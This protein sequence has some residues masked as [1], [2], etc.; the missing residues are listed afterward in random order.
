MSIR[1]SAR[2]HSP[3]QVLSA[4]H[5]PKAVL[6]VGSDGLSLIG[7][8]PSAVNARIV[9]VRADTGAISEELASKFSDLK[10]VDA[11]VSSRGGVRPYFEASVQ[12]GS[13]L[14]HPDVL[15]GLWKNIKVQEEREVDTQAVSEIIQSHEIRPDWLFVGTLHAA[16]LMSEPYAWTDSVD[17]IALRT[18]VD[19]TDISAAPQYA[20]ASLDACM[21]RSGYRSVAALPARHPK[22]CTAIYVR[23]WKAAA[24][25]KLREQASRFEEQLEEKSVEIQNLSKEK[26]D[27]L[28]QL[29]DQSD[30]QSV[31]EDAALASKR[32]QLA[33][34]DLEDLRRRQKTMSE[35]YLE[36]AERLKE[37]EAHLAAAHEQLLSDLECQ[38]VVRSE[39]A[40]VE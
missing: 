27:L 31:R 30:L 19:P 22:L 2:I 4:L 1:V 23:D 18:V 12:Q 14:L 20:K 9:C 38:E 11:V 33:R 8:V 5:P 10:F 13:G 32:E 39:E 40:Q 17:V 15:N 24:L 36:Q 35:A 29:E 6:M 25:D 7:D 21:L 34:N 26:G 28:V 37:I 3:L 16:E